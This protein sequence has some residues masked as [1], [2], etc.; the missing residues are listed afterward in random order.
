MLQN[1]TEHE[2]DIIEC[3]YIYN[4]SIFY[5]NILKNTLKGNPKKRYNHKLLNINISDIF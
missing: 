2:L 1:K 3:E 5:N 4:V